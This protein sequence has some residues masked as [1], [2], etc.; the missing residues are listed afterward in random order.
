MTKADAAIMMEKS[1]FDETSK[2]LVS[3]KRGANESANEEP[4]P[5]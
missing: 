5:K 4:A 3:N 2:I 1:A